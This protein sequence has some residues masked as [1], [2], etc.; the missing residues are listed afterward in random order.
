[1][2]PDLGDQVDNHYW[3]I[4]GATL[5]TSVL[6]TG[7]QLSQ[8]QQSNALQS[9]GIGQTLGQSVGTQI[10]STGTMLLQKNINIQPTLHIRAG[11]EFTVEVN[12][13]IIF[14][15]SYTGNSHKN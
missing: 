5:L 15:K 3:R 10:A 2:E 1:M 4:F 13:D 12:K 7:A 14:P 11:F 8:P 9:P 6:A